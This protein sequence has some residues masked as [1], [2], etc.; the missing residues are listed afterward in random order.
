LMSELNGKQFLQ[1][2]VWSSAHIARLRHFKQGKAADFHQAVSRHQ[3]SISSCVGA[4]L[5]A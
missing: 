1:K 3:P 4:E 5:A 2:A